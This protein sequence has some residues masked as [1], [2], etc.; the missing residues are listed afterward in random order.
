M[1]DEMAYQHENIRLYR[2]SASTQKANLGL[3]NAVIVM[4]MP[5]G[6]TYCHSH[7]IH[8]GVLIYLAQEV[9]VVLHKQD[10][11]IQFKRWSDHRDCMRLA[12]KDIKDFLTSFFP[13]Q[14]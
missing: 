3:Y 1:P 11:M 7:S 6:I 2:S 14:T 9:H 5:S 4:S 10:K 12:N 13:F 8:S